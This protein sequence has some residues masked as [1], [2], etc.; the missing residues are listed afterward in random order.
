MAHCFFF[1]IS[2]VKFWIENI[3]I[4]CK[5]P[6]IIEYILLRCSPIRLTSYN[7]Y[8]L[9]EFQEILSNITKVIMIQKLK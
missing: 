2:I 9:G 8:L 5:K 7:V 1:L 6:L 4:Y 3:K